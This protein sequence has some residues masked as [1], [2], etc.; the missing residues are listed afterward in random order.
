MDHSEEQESKR[1]P[2][3]NLELRRL[4]GKKGQ[5]HFEVTLRDKKTN[6]TE[7]MIEKKEGEP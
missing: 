1:V 6:F 4:L 7:K 5:L 2:R 3:Q